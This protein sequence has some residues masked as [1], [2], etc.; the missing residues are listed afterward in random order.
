VRRLISPY[1]GNLMNEKSQFSIAII[2]VQ[3]SKALS[4]SRH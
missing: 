3:E 2:W 1:R 4:E